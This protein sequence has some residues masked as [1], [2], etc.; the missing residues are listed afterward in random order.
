MQILI[1]KGFLF[2]KSLYLDCDICC[3]SKKTLFELMK[4]EKSGRPRFAC[5]YFNTIIAV[6]QWYLLEIIYS[7]KF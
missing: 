1:R 7:F 2:L 4:E 5:S 3:H 6:L